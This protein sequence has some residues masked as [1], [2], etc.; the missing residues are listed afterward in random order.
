[1]AEGNTQTKEA[2]VEK[3]LVS[4]LTQ[5]LCAVVVEARREAGLTHRADAS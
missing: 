3:L 4:E 5:C 1:M 2:I